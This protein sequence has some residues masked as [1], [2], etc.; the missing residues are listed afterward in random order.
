MRILALLLVALAARGQCV[1]P[2]KIA[3]GPRSIQAQCS[4]WSADIAAEGSAVVG[5]W[6]TSVTS[7]VSQP[8]TRGTTA[9]GVL[10]ARGRL[11]SAEQLPMND[12]PGYPSVATN[13]QQSL[14]AWS[15]KDYGTFAQFL[16]ADGARIGSP[17]QLSE[18][19]VHWIAPRALWNGREWRVA[20]NEG[21]NAVSMRVAPDGT[22]A[23]GKLIAANA[24]V[25]AGKGD[26]IVVSTGAG[27]RLVTP[28]G[29]QPLL[30]IP[31][32]ATIALG[33]RFLAWHDGTIG[34]LRLPAGNPIVIAT[35]S[36][37]WTNIAT[38]GDVVLWSDGATT[39]GAYVNGDGSTRP[40]GPVAGRPHAAAATPEGVVALL[41][42]TCASVTSRF[43]PNGATAFAAGESVSR[44]AAPQIPHALVQTPGGHHLVWSEPRPVEQGSRLYVT[45]V[46]GF[47]ARP[48]VEL[49]AAF[50]APAAAAPLA[51]GSVVVWAD[52]TAGSAPSVLKYAR[53]DAAGQ[54]RGAPA[55]LATTWFVFEIA[56]AARGEEIA[57]FTLEHETYAWI[58]DLW[59]T[60]IAAD[61]AVTREKLAADV[62]GWSLD[63][64][65]TPEGVVASW[66]DYAGGDS[67][68]L[69]VRDPGGTRTFPLPM[70]LQAVTLTGGTT[71]LV[72]WR[73]A[74]VHA[75]FPRTGA[76]AFAVKEGEHGIG[77]MEATQQPD[78]SFNVATAPY[79]PAP[80]QITIVNVTPAGVV[81]PREE[82]CFSVPA[83]LLSMR[84]PTVDAIVTRVNGGVFL[85][86]RTPPRRRAVR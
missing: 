45:P 38:A 31:A 30:A 7:G 86:K 77:V 37:T 71:P 55:A 32:N 35:A 62:D 52:S 78:G 73:R 36:A 53:V 59:K 33:D 68:L 61:G 58:G 5:A 41:S 44:V 57:V 24:T 11:L 70:P 83:S 21:P 76:D 6:V 29:T 18:S 9:G 67:L 56:V 22:V 10:D 69:T 84:G 54:L 60:T 27:F 1:D 19:G 50:G 25:V 66:Y 16:D 47:A 48:P 46:D 81:T 64:T 74:D 65:L 39:H 23:D 79:D 8:Y 2:V 40:I 42:D 51:G 80:A 43:L 13:G 85:A 26:R 82:L 34:V 72:L 14:L 15:R 4:Y 28:A 12:A 3:A 63:A 17:I 49:S 75:L 20:Y